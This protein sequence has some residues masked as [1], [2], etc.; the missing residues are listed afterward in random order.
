MRAHQRSITHRWEDSHTAIER[1]CEMHRDIEGR[2]LEKDFD[3][4]APV[5]GG[6]VAHV[7]LPLTPRE[8]GGVHDVCPTPVYGGLA[9]QV[10]GPPT[11]EIRW[12]GQPHCVSIDLLHLHPRYRWE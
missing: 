9:A 5:R 11:R 8:F 2:N 3:L 6:L 4:Y 7:P 10:L 1:H 12:D